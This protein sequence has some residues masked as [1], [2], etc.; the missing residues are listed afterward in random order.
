MMEKMERLPEKHVQKGSMVSFV[1]YLSD[2]NLR[3]TVSGSLIFGMY[4]LALVFKDYILLELSFF[5]VSL[6]SF[7]LGMPC[8]NLQEHDWI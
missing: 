7:P 2:P 6:C 8:W 3:F 4:Y 1:R 5:I